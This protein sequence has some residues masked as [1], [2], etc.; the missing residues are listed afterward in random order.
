M[1]YQIK[2]A[3]SI[4]ETFEPRPWMLLEVFP[5]KNEEGD[6]LAYCG[7]ESPKIAGIRSDLPTE[8]F[9]HQLKDLDLSD[10]YAVADFMTTYGMIGSYSAGRYDMGFYL[11]S[12]RF[13]LS[14]SKGILDFEGVYCFESGI[15]STSLNPISENH[16]TYYQDLLKGMQQ[17]V[18]KERDGSLQSIRCIVS[19]IEVKRSVWELQRCAKITKALV[20]TSSLSKIA[21]LL[22]L[23]EDR[24]RHEMQESDEYINYLLRGVFPEIGIKEV[25]NDSEVVASH[26]GL[27]LD[28]VGSFEEAVALQ[29]WEFA[30]EGGSYRTCKE[31]RQVF[32]RK[33]SD[34]RKSTARSDS[35]FCCDRCRNRFTQ[36]E[37]RKTA[38]YKL[39]QKKLKQQKQK[40][41]STQ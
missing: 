33:Q 4:G 6:I 29:L 32:Q 12:G 25:S 17:I 11:E 5:V 14:D 18:D 2:R 27:T 13:D 24:V 36:R 9:S 19:D 40:A 41:K 34:S 37:H 39:K 8:I 20:Q 26:E 35:A 3:F 31:C 23:P 22:K 38:G 21:C 30:L 16:F 10:V 7:M 15:I 1:D 28:K